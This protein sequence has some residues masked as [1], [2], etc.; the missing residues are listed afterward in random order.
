MVMSNG[1]RNNE[2]PGG[3][4]SIPTADFSGSAVGPGGQ[5]CLVRKAKRSDDPG[6]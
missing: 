1:E 4:E 2:Q 3:E 5:S 6:G